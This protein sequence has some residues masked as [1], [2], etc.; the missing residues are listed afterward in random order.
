MMIQPSALTEFLSGQYEHSIV[1]SCSKGSA[2]G[3]IQTA[4][5]YVIPFNP[6]TPAQVGTRKLFKDASTF[7]SNAQDKTIGAAVFSRA[8]YLADLIEQTKKLAYRGVPTIGTSAGRQAMVMGGI[9]TGIAQSNYDVWAV[10]PQDATTEQ[11]LE[12]ILQNIAQVL[13]EN[14]NRKQRERIGFV[15]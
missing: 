12:D 5:K 8:T 13:T 11:Q 14:A 1:F 6:N 3:Y 9:L 4:R 2:S 7:F 10:L 15:G